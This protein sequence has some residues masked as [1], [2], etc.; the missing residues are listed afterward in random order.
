MPKRNL[1]LSVFDAAKERISYCFDNYEKIIISFSGGKDSTVMT[2][3][4]MEEAIKR[5]RK[6]ALLFIDWE[7]QFSLTISHIKNVYKLYANNIE[8]YWLSVP[9]TTDNACSQI[10]TTWTC[11][12]QNKKDLW[13]RELED[14]MISDI[15][16]FPFYYEGIT[17]EE[18]TPL[19]AK[20]YAK[21]SQTCNFMGLRADESLNR[22]RAV[23]GG[24]LNN[25][26]VK[27]ITNIV[28]EVFAAYPIYDFQTR[29]IWIYNYKTKKPYNK[30]YDRMWQA[31]LSIHQMRI[32][33]PFGD[34][35]RRGL[36]LYQIIEPKMWAK[37]VARVAGANVV[38]EYGRQRGNILG[39]QTISL[40]EGHTWKSFSNFLLD[41]MP[42]PTR[43][44]YKNKIAVYLQWFKVR[45]YPDGIPDE[46][47]IEIQHKAPS[48]KMICKA[49][50]KN[51]YW[52]RGLGFS[53]TKSSN[54]QKYLDL[55][56]RRRIAWTIYDE[57][58]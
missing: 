10:E 22:F 23:M 27:Y 26:G 54:Y 4:I 2:H 50:L 33:E 45:S 1:G 55:M 51:D 3:L 30:L 12:D 42:K 31:G 19:F 35:T 32:D 7:C 5:N 25:N 9:L 15:K 8:P 37:L 14:I 39:N 18:F 13:V 21:G 29:D 28:D 49:L 6:V 17:F 24:K 40:P 53:I 41:T 48:W 20:W 36:Y 46:V 52:C 57:N 47:P 16:V 58:L 56:R 34:T 38:N 43:E 11:W 44:H